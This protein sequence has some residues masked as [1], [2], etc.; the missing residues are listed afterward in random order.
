MGSDKGNPGKKEVIYSWVQ[1]EQSFRLLS[2][3]AKGK[4]SEYFSFIVEE[5]DFGK[6]IKSRKAD[7][8]AFAEL[9]RLTNK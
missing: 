1:G 4:G 6:W 8:A 3:K 9:A 2:V 7:I 5:D